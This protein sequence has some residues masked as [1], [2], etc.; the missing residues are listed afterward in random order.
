[1][2]S[3]RHTR[4]EAK[5]WRKSSSTLSEVLTREAKKKR[6]AKNSGIH[7]K[8][9]LSPELAK[10]IGSNEPETRY[11]VVKLIWKQIKER[12][13]QDPENPAYI[14]CDEEFEE[15]TGLVRLKGFT[16]IKYLNHHFLE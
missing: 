14:D 12:N 3:R 4:K 15:V 6:A 1:M 7:R 9:R 8:Y 11:N 16:I 10:L 2:G 13:L 5:L